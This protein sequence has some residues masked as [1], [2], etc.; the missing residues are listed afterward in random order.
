MRV[1]LCI[2][3]DKYQRINNLQS[4]ED[5]A[6]RLFGVLTDRDRGQYDPDKS[7]LLLSPTLADVRN[8]ISEILYSGELVTDF[9][10]TFSGH[11]GVFFD[12]FYLALSDSDPSKIAINALSFSDL[13]KMVVAAQPLQANFIVDA[14]NA[15]GLGF[16]LSAILTQS[17]TGT[18]SSTG[19]SALAA[20]A[21]D[22]YAWEGGNGGK[23]TNEI[24]KILSG[25]IVLQKH[26][27]YLDLAELGA[28][29]QLDTETEESQTVSTWVL[30]LQGPNRFCLNPFYS[31]DISRHPD[32]ATDTIAYRLKLSD[33]DIL[34]IKRVLFDIDE[35]VD[36]RHLAEE[37][38]GVLISL[39]PEAQ[40]IFLTGMAESFV[41]A[42]R[43]NSDPFA[44]GRVL[45]VFI[46]LLF[47]IEVGGAAGASSYVDQLTTEALNS[48]FRAIFQIKDSLENNKY[49]LFGED[50]LAD[51]FF[52]PI[53]ISDIIGRIGVQFF[54]Y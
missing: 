33:S 37:L 46:G 16:D 47:S 11:G 50:A 34:K 25:E 32:Y 38:E 6:R 53:R 7:Q 18:Q 10:F 15:G 13:A 26:K 14:C 42:A 4:A 54:F 12:S 41:A 31:G 5:D 35:V 1:A 27:P 17:L 2:G 8:S 45:S 52:L 9:V 44:E 29:I 36:E 51:L 23:F 49:A 3:C 48:D 24:M 39:P 22:E 21:A 30:N 19:V 20:A 43:R 28:A 40:R